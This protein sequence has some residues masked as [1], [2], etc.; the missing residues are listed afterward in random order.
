MISALCFSLSPSGAIFA[1]AIATS[2]GSLRPTAWSIVVVTGTGWQPRQK[3]SRTS[4]RFRPGIPE[5]P[6]EAGGEDLTAH[7]R[8]DPEMAWWAKRQVGYRGTVVESAD[9]VI[10]VTVPVANPEAFIGW[11]LSFDDN[12][13]LIAPPELR[14]RLIDRVREGR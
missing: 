4:G 6:W 11:L 14:Q 1:S 3:P 7:V 5:T 8:F 10:D 9:G 12:A 2:R 13:E